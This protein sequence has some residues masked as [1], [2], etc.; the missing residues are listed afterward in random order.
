MKARVIDTDRMNAF[1]DGVYAVA[2]TLLALNIQ[3]PK[4]QD[5]SA[6]ALITELLRQ[7]PYY[8]AYVVSFLVIGSVWINHHQMSRYIRQADHV[9]M[10]LNILLLLDV[11]LIPFA[12][13]LLA[14]FM[15]TPAQAQVA[16][17]VYGAIWTIG[18]IFFNVTWWYAC[19][20]KYV[21]VQLT[22][23][24]LDNITRR[25]RA[26]PLL[27]LLGCL[28]SFISAWFSL[29]LYLLPTVL[30]LLPDPESR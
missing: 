22:A 27:Y 13:N 1:S 23:A 11:V 14:L 10:I 8:L 5:T 21:D 25:Y 20:R 24:E 19:R 6:Q 29:G 15:I 9:L 18:G 2:I 7:W 28:A 4:P 16:T 3:A 17:F 26:G 12:T 30:F